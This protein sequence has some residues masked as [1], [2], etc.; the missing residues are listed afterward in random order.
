[1]SSPPLVGYG[2]TQN[3]P[4]D[5][6]RQMHVPHITSRTLP[7]LPRVSFPRACLVLVCLFLLAVLPRSAGALA[8]TASGGADSPDAETSW[9]WPVESARHITEPFRAPSH[10]YGPGHRGIDL[11]APVGSVI[12]APAHGVIAF[13]GVVVDRPLITI[14]HGAGVVTTYE[15]VTSTLTPGSA[16]SAGDKIGTVA[17]GGHT[18]AGEMH[19]GV[20]W[21]DVYINP[22]L[23]FGEVP[24]AILLPCCE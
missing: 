19:L 12:R 7:P 3:L 5:Q 21:N 13:R 8:A 16:V 22:Q 15:P 4:A 17:T 1:M 10:A 24:R 6:H 14:D 2:H 18:P 9:T 20:R 23:M 11:S